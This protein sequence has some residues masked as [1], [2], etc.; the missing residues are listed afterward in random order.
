MT[1]LVESFSKTVWMH[2]LQIYVSLR[3]KSSGFFLKFGFI[4]FRIKLYW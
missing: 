3:R 1:A 4:G 2:D